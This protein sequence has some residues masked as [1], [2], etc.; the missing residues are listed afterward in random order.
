MKSQPH[1]LGTMGLTVH[2]VASVLGVGVLILPGAV[3]RIAGESAMLA[4]LL[5]VLFS[6]PFARAFAEISIRHPTASGVID[7]I[8]Q[9]FG[10]TVSSAIALF[11]LATLIIANPLLGVAS[12]RFA[13]EAFAIPAEGGVFYVAGYAVILITA[14]LNIFGLRAN[15]AVQSTVLI[16]LILV[17]LWICTAALV[18]VP[19]KFLTGNFLILEKIDPYLVVSGMLLAFFGFIGWE[20]A[21]PVAG[22]V[23]NPSATY[24]NAIKLGIGLVGG[25]YIY[26]AYVVSQTMEIIDADVDGL[27]F[28]KNLI[29]YLYGADAAQYAA[30]IAALLMFLTMNAWT[31]GTS[32]YLYGLVSKGEFGQVKSDRGNLRT[33]NEKTA[34][35]LVVAAYGLVVLCLAFTGGAEISLIK[36]SSGLF[37]L[38][39]IISLLSVCIIL[40]EWRYRVP[41]IFVISLLIILFCSSVANIL[42]SLSLLSLAFC[43]VAGITKYKTGAIAVRR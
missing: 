9:V 13:L 23:K 18:S 15:I 30:L 17:L 8:E 3:Y 38:F 42:I 31:L 6:W 36:L 4:W 2:Y 5:L 40:K 35:I 43:I 24:P 1:K 21:A 37:L 11:L 10:K 33:M 19:G 28:F 32:K 41:I 26:M 16:L 27:L 29:A 14:M 20:N 34:I 12:G 39:F 25:L 22:D 7:L